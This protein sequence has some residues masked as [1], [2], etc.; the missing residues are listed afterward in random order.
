LYRRLSVFVGGCTL[1]AA[2]AVCDPD[3]SLGL[4]VLDGMAS[5][6]A[7]SIVRQAEGPD[8]EPRF[9]MLETIREFGLE[10]LEESGES[11]AIRQRHRDWYLAF[12]ERVSAELRGPRQAELFDLL[13]VEHDNL[14]SSFEWSTA[15]PDGV[16]AGATLAECLAWFWVVRGHLREGRAYLDRL[17]ARAP[18]G[19]PVRAT[20]LSVAG[21]LAERQGDYASAQPLLEE[22]LRL[23]RLLGNDRGVASVLLTLRPIVADSGDSERAGA[24]LHECADLF[25]KGGAE[26]PRDSVIA[27]YAET[28]IGALASLAVQQGDLAAAQTLYDEDL[29]L[30]GA[31]GDPHGVANALRGLGSLACN[32]R[33]FERARDLFVQSLRRFRDLRDVPCVGINLGWLAIVAGAADQ[34]DRAARL[35]AASEVLQQRGGVSL[36]ASVRGDHDRWKAQVRSALGEVAFE[37]VSADGRSMSLE[38]AVAYALKEQPST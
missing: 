13:A 11:S 19:G 25:R 18:D 6:V 17:I 20:I 10:Q 15:E 14:R 22:A 23:W 8:G 36:P 27:G 2:E 37:A 3:G 4:D 32:R 35:F 28:P 1:E 26:V 30:S 29:A 12:A 9:G 5:L 16:G 24:L 21:F 7:Q 31:R 33:D 34:Q 38:Q